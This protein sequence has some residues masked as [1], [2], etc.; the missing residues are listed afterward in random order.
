MEEIEEIKTRLSRLEE[1]VWGMDYETARRVVDSYIGAT[2]ENPYIDA[3]P[4][5][6]RAEKMLGV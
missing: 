6:L 1:A 2:E 4:A 3:S 5:V